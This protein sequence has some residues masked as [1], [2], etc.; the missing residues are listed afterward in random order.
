MRLSI[1]STVSDEGAQNAACHSSI[2]VLRNHA[3]PQ[4]CH[5]ST[6]ALWQSRDS[7]ATGRYC[8]ADR[9]DHMRK[10]I[11]A[12]ESALDN[13][14]CHASAQSCPQ[15]PTCVLALEN[16][17]GS[18]CLNATTAG[19]NRRRNVTGMWSTREKSMRL[20]ISAA[21]THARTSATS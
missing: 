14:P 21:A 2:D 19:A 13:P 11:S 3:A 8:A 9:L 5:A 15:V 17:A 12:P 20:C 1:G 16:S 6:A 18:N 4:A 10:V 7:D